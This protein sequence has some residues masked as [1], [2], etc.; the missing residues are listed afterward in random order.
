MVNVVSKLIN[1]SKDNVHYGVYFMDPVDPDRDGVPNY[2]KFIQ[3]PM[4]LG[5]I[6]NRIYLDYYKNCQLFWNDLGLVFKNCRKFNVDETSDIRI[7]CD[8]LRELAIDLYK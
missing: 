8:T 7:L 3:T 1:Y 4:D 6:M 5:T 2:K